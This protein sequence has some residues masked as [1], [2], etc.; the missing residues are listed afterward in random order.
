MQEHGNYNFTPLENCLVQA[1]EE[2]NIS[3]GSIHD[4][5]LMSKAI[6]AV[7]SMNPLSLLIQENIEI[8]VVDG[9]AQFPAGVITVFAFRY[10]DHNGFAYGNYFGS[11]D[12]LDRCNCYI[13]EG[14]VGYGNS[15]VYTGDAIKFIQPAMAPEKIKAS[16][17]MRKM[18]AD[19]KL[20]MIRDYME[21]PVTMFMC[22]RFANRFIRNYTP[23]QYED[24]K[25]RWIAGRGAVISG[26]AQ[27]D[28]FN[29]RHINARMMHPKRI[30]IF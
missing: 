23:L 28:W 4:V 15:V 13:E 21:E 19:N 5:W 7:R 27:R 3:E 17:L 6:E 11:F 9:V 10:C 14:Y 26:D 1:K 18:D 30:Q 2:L 29:K 8:D 25:S 24:W 12:W 16:V 22:Y 20:F